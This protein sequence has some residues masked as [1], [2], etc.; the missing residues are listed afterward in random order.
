MTP[1]H[2]LSAPDMPLHEGVLW[3]EEKLLDVAAELSNLRDEYGI[4][5]EGPA[6]RVATSGGVVDEDDHS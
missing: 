6:L 1:R 4:G 3:L 2:P 5:D